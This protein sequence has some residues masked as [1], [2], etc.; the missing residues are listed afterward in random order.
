V[1]VCHTEKLKNVES[2]VAL[3]RCLTDPLPVLVV[4]RLTVEAT[5]VSQQFRRFRR[6]IRQPDQTLPREV[7]D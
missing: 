5:F 7:Q 6:L 4:D 3:T 2:K 1:G